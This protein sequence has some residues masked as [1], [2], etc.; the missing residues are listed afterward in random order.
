MARK[1]VTTITCDG[2]KKIGKG[3]VPATVELKIGDV[4]YDLC[5][6]HGEKFAALL[7]EALG[8]DEHAALSA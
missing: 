6:P 3:E 7:F 2:C 5:D 4:Q 8:H 1:V